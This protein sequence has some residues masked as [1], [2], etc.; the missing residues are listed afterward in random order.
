M[1][2]LINSSTIQAY[3]G[4]MVGSSVL[5]LG[6][7]A[8]GFANNS[9][10]DP[11]RISLAVSRT[12]Q[13]FSFAIPIIAIEYKYWKSVNALMAKDPLKARI[14]AAGFVII[15]SYAVVAGIIAFG[16]FP[17]MA[18]IKPDQGS[19][20]IKK[21]TPY[22]CN[23]FRVANIACLSI[24]LSKRKISRPFG[25]LAIAACFVTALAQHYSK[26]DNGRYIWDGNF[27]K[28]S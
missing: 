14:L 22:I 16:A 25:S 12:V 17:V 7:R 19:K 6:I 11:I 13:S 18:L 27:N 1:L 5:D 9:K 2:D 26:P 10:K 15:F 23:L 21:I 28:L 4:I 20:S 8:Y 3:S 24:M